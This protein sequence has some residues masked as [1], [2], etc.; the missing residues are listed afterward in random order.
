MAGL[1]GWKTTPTTIADSETNQWLAYCDARAGITTALKAVTPTCSQ[2]IIN[3]LA[4]LPSFG[5]GFNIFFQGYTFIPTGFVDGGSS[6]VITDGMGGI[7]TQAI[8]IITLSN[9]PGPYNISTSGTTLSPN[10]TDYTVTIT[11]NVADAALGLT[12][13]KTTL[14]VSA[15]PHVLPFTPPTFGPTPS[16]PTCCPDIGNYSGVVTSGQTT[17]PLV[18][19]LTYIPRFV[20]YVAKNSGTPIAVINDSLGPYLT[21]TA[22][23]AFITFAYAASGGGVVDI[24]WIAYR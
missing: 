15:T 12:C 3:W 10:A 9:T 7:I 23:G 1:V 11:S 24:D 16:S 14:A 18:T 6:I 20:S 5:T 17:I 19:G 13:Q 2:V 21:Y 4:Y 22:K 8:D